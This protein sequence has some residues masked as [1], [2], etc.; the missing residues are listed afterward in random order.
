[1]GTDGRQRPTS[2]QTPEVPEFVSNSPPWLESSISPEPEQFGEA[3]WEG[4]GNLHDKSFNVTHAG[5]D[6]NEQV[7]PE[8]DSVGISDSL[9]RGGHGSV[10]RDTTPRIQT[11]EPS[12]DRTDDL[13]PLRQVSQDSAY[14]SIMGTKQSESEVDLDQ[15]AANIKAR[16]RVEIIRGRVLQTRNVMSEKRQEL[17][18]LR[19]ILRDTTD[20]LMRAV[21]KLM[22][23]ENIKDLR[24]LAPYHEALQRAQDDLGPAENA[25][26]LL[27]IRLNREEEELEEEEKYFY[28]HNHVPLAR[29]S[30]ARLEK[31]LT[32]RTMPY[33]PE[34]QSPSNLK[35]E[36]E[37]VQVYFD[38]VAGAEIFK[39][40]LHELE[41][42]QYSLNQELFFRKRHE[43][44]LSKEKADF[45]DNFPRLRRDLIDAL[46]NLEDDLHEIRDRC[47]K[48][49]LFGPSDYPYEPYDALV[50][51]IYDSIDDVRDQRPLYAHYKKHLADFEKKQD[52][53]NTWL[54]EWIQESTVEILQ[55]RSFI[56]TEY[57]VYGKELLGDD[58]SDLA[59]EFW[60][61][62]SAGKAANREQR[63]STIDA[64]LGGT[65]SSLEIEDWTFG[66][67]PVSIS[68]SLWDVGIDLPHVERVP[69]GQGPV[70]R[71]RRAS[72]SR[73][74]SL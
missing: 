40:Q 56:Y 35:L 65:G 36:P 8:N 60:D 9:A 62:D 34:G 26:D 15:Q 67:E 1:M 27:E 61:R 31:T 17:Q 4:T 7:L 72:H 50:E 71:R 54:L 48:E 3:G 30:D 51:E 19:E 20:D 73:A 5:Q 32:P 55:L 10:D 46:E 52:Y 42:K 29:P 23:F 74:R 59:L 21:N 39:E 45:L 66:H 43:L 13:S 64:L 2:I 57:P 41:D 44:P 68:R 70:R 11:A 14:E 53:V 16:E 24:S 47:I 38:K 33:D 28:T 22:A 69:A 63:K 58:W 25:Y 12:L 49:N 18:F 6:D 37:L